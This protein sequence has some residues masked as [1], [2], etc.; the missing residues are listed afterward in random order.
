MAKKTDQ[1][2]S[3]R[4]AIAKAALEELQYCSWSDLSLI[5]IANRLDVD[6]GR[7]Y[8]SIPSRRLLVHAVV[9]FLI[10]ETDLPPPDASDS[11]NDRLFG[12]FM[13]LFDVLQKYRAS[14]LSIK[15]AASQ[16]PKII[17]IV[18]AELHNA[19]P[20][21]LRRMHLAAKG[22]IG[23]RN[24]ALVALWCKLF[25]LWLNDNST[26]LSSTMAGVDRDVARF[27]NLIVKKT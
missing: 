6:A 21:L 12:L 9:D 8:S 24:L 26:D 3:L 20:S 18:F 4:H 16:N 17:G 14:I 10:S 25:K 23:L 19:I 11:V 7:I 5:Q 2:S 1:T 27:A 15:K 13:G 22:F